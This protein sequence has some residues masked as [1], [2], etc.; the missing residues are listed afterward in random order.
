M[1]LLAYL[2]PQKLDPEPAA[3]QA[4][5]YILRPR[6]LAAA[7]I[8]RLGLD[9]GFEFGHIESERRFE[10]GQ[11][12][13]TIFD[14]EG[15]RRIFIENKFWA[16]LTDAQ[17]VRYLADLPDDLPSGLVFIVPEQR[18]P[19]VW[20]ELKRRSRESY[21][22]EEDSPSDTMTQLQMGTRTMCI[23]SWRHVLDLLKQISPD[24]DLRCDVMQ[25]GG[26]A[27][28]SESDEF[29]PLRDDEISDVSIPSRMINY[30]NLVE[31]IFDALVA[32]G[33]ARKGR[34]RITNDWHD[35]GR[36]FTVLDKFEVWLGVAREPWRSTSI[37]PLWLRVTSGECNLGEDYHRLDK[38]FENVQEGKNV[39][40]LPI[41]LRTGVERDEVI[42]DAVKEV[43]CI[44]EKFGKMVAATGRSTETA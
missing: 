44:A 1:S 40:Y 16:G 34:L 17:P 28:F 29:P 4:L 13:L 12:D 27:R 9:S 14:S 37:G 22:L 25:L 5:A 21:E 33:V 43:Q 41:P 8:R 3:T 20:E 38:S 35:T 10:G 26:L 31:P 42:R 11:P 24:D 7:F 15:R 23:T 32:L 39:K 36:Y 6:E 30:C 19:T 18:I 2:I